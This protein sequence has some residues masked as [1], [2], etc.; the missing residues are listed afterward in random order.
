MELNPYNS[1]K[2]GHLF[3]GYIKLRQRILNGLNNGKSFAVMGGR[4]CGKTSLL[5]QLEKDLKEVSSAQQALLP[6]FMDIQAELPKST[7]EFWACISRLTVADTDL[8]LWQAEQ[9]SQPYQAFLAWL[10]Q[11]IPRMTE[12]HGANW[13]IVLLIDELEVAASRL[14]NDDCF[15][16]LRHFLMNSEFASRFRVVV[17]GVGGLSNLIKSGSPLN[18]LES[19]TLSHLSIEESRQ[20][21][22]QG[23]GKTFPALLESKLQELSG[24]HPWLLQGLLEYLW[25]AQQQLDEESLRNAV[26]Q[27]TRSRDGIFKSWAKTLDVG[28]RTVCQLLAAQGEISTKQIRPLVPQTITVT[29]ILDVLGYH[30]LVDE[31]DDE[32]IK[33]NGMLFR[34]WFTQN[35][36]YLNLGDEPLQSPVLAIEDKAGAVADERKRHVFVVYGRDRKFHAEVCLFLRALK[37]E[38]LEWNRIV[39]ATGKG[40]P[41]IFEIIEKG[42][43]MAGAAVVLLTPDDEARLLPHFHQLHD[44]AHEKELTPQPRPNVLFEAGLAMAK[45]QDKTILVRAGQVRPFSDIAGMHLLDIDNEISKRDHFAKRLENC[46]LK[47]DRSGIYWQ[48]AGDLTATKIPG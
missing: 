27:F 29:E 9:D 34:D 14:P 21:I 48:Q 47:V 39:E 45:F 37:L 23:F 17:S 42:F 4:R 38:P 13:T 10:K 18:N 20:L 15:H 46:G 1:T 24:Y 28:G 3:T 2:P 33:L 40:A 19:H 7:E 32:R 43:S 41:T 25:E 12:I 22:E 30:G 8:P 44:A 11:T 6:Q 16:N 36:P 35:L 26:R 5:R 31:A